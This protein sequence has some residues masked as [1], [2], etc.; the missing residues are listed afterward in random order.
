MKKIKIPDELLQSNEPMPEI[1]LMNYRNERTIVRYR[2]NF[3]QHVFSFLKAGAKEIF[4]DQDPIFLTNRGFAL[5]TTPNCLMTETIP[6]ASLYKSILLFFSHKMLEAFKIKYRDLIAAQIH[7]KPKAVLAFEYDDY[8]FHFR[9]SLELLMAQP[10]PLP[11]AILNAKFE[12]IMLYLLRTQA[13][14]INRLLSTKQTDFEMTFKSVV[15]SNIHSHLNLEELAFLCNMSLST[16]KRHFAQFYQMS[17]QKW[18][19]AERMKTAAFLIKNGERPVD[20]FRKLGYKTLSNFVRAYKS[21][22]QVA[23]KQQQKMDV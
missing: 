1:Q 5:I 8:C 10:G 22:F 15:E 20:I 19:I 17:P 9:S 6:E 7:E 2:V 14:K 21:H 18:I 4:Y 11:T 13:E 16:F 23:P 12:E 3:S